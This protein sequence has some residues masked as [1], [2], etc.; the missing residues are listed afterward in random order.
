MKVWARKIRN[1][2][3]SSMCPWFLLFLSYWSRWWILK[4]NFTLNPVLE[5]KKKRSVFWV[6]FIRSLNKS[7][8]RKNLIFTENRQRKQ[9]NYF[10]KKSGMYQSHTCTKYHQI[11][12][13]FWNTNNVPSKMECRIMQNKS[14][15]KKM[16]KYWC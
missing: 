15:G 7:K 2:H 14:L 3:F 5:M 10:T 8:K 9:T 12:N 13:F 6:K 16:L 1:K 11:S 4:V